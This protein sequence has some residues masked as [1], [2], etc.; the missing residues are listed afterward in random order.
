MT[1]IMQTNDF[2]CKLMITRDFPNPN[3][4][5]RSYQPSHISTKWSGPVMLIITRDDCI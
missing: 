2:P 4:T 3:P 1:L 5:P